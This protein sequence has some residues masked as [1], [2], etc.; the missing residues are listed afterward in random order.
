MSQPLPVGGNHLTERLSSSRQAGHT[1]R[2][3][4]LER[5]RKLCS[6][7]GPTAVSLY[8]SNKTRKFAA[9]FARDGYETTRRGH[10][11]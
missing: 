11:S 3:C 8:F 9:S 2:G 6:L 7:R 10:L 4:S 5:H 1:Q